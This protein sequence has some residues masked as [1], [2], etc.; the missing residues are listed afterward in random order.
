MLVGLLFHS[1]APVLAEP[2]TPTQGVTALAQGLCISTA[3]EVSGR[4]SV[5]L[6]PPGLMEA[7][8]REPIPTLQKLK[9]VGNVLM[10]I[11]AERVIQPPKK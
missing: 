10:P 6:L 2:I 5:H 11:Q 7:C 4:P 1:T 8:E 9:G 3:L